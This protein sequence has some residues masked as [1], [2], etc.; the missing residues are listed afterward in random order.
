MGEPHYRVSWLTKG[1][2][3]LSSQDSTRVNQTDLAR[4]AIILCVSHYPSMAG[5]P[6]PAP[7]GARDIFA[8]CDGNLL[9]LI[10]DLPF[11]FPSQ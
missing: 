3:I 2:A 10:M 4:G 8:H 7:L 5:V 6:M 11:H 1:E 9:S